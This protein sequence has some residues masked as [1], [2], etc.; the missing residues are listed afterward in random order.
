S[1]MIKTG[2]ANVSPVEIEVALS[3][4]PGLRAGLAVGIPHPSLG[5]V[6][7]LCA[8]PIRSAALDAEAI[9]SYLRERLSAYKV[10][11][12]VLFFEEDEIAFTGNQKIQVGPLREEVLRRL[13]AGRTVIDGYA[14]D[15]GE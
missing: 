6:V 4:C 5:E 1:D 3:D 9:R 11:K 10:P 2:G 13:R 7:I 15:N 12:H 8:L 14:Y